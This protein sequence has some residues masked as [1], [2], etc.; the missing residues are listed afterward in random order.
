ML[1]D[2]S[3]HKLFP[4][5]KLPQQ[6]LCCGYMH[7]AVTCGRLALMVVYTG[8]SK[9]TKIPMPPN[10]NCRERHNGHNDNGSQYKR[11]T[12]IYRRM[13]I[14]S[15]F[16]GNFTGGAKY[17]QFRLCAKLY[18]SLIICHHFL[19]NN[20]GWPKKSK[21]LPILQKIVLKIANEIRFLRKVKV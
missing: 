19:Y 8:A 9:E 13:N 10:M 18:H 1:F 21:P 2:F 5:L 6:N 14:N 4:M 20:T 16:Q 7:V 15:T 11:C 12:N 3:L 17:R